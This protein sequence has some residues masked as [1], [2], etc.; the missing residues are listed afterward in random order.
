MTITKKTHFQMYYYRF[1]FF[2]FKFPITSRA[3]DFDLCDIYIVNVLCFLFSLYNLLFFSHTHTHTHT[4]TH[5]RARARAR[6]HAH[7]QTL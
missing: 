6:T 4:H 7:A 2:V 3:I 5:A 1:F